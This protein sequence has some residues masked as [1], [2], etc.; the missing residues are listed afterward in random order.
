MDVMSAGK[1]GGTTLGALPFCKITPP[2]AWLAA[3]TP[4]QP[5][6][7][8]S[9]KG[10]YGDVLIIGGAT[11]MVGAAILAASAALHHG[12]GRTL[13]HLLSASARP[14]EIYAPLPDL[15]LPDA[16]TARALLAHATV[17]CGC[18]GGQDVQT[19]LP[20]VLMDAPRLVLDADALNA[21]AQNSDLQNLLKKRDAH[22][23]DTILTPHPLEAARLLNSS[24]PHIQAERMQSAQAM[25]EH[26]QCTVLLKGSGSIIASP[27]TI[28]S[29]NPTGNARLAIGGTGDVLTGLIAAQWH[30]ARDAHAVAQQAA[31]EHG[32]LADLWPK[33]Q[34]LTASRL[35]Q[36]QIKNI[37]K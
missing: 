16:D 26:F 19:W 37:K 5:R 21:I 1:Y 25:A 24:T 17:V 33:E 14:L 10:S 12:S 4:P 18:G 28:P 2:D 36:A 31:W 7:H 35:A 34:V 22:G 9:H 3:V 13:L 6:C 27:D 23:Q 15:M 32:A 20:K 30:S 29:I 8:N 11:G